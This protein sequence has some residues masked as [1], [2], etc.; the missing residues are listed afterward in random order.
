MI[1]YY[2]ILNKLSGTR[3]MIEFVG[4]SHLSGGEKKLRT[5][6]KRTC[7]WTSTSCDLPALPTYNIAGVPCLPLSRYLIQP[8][9][10]TCCDL[11]LSRTG[12]ILMRSVHLGSAYFVNP[13]NLIVCFSGRSD[14]GETDAVK[15]TKLENW[16]VS[17]DSI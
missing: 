12:S 17:Y 5:E 9:R 4:G 8:I 16:Y 11:L 10:S 15:T 2:L 3:L 14:S 13:L 1:N 7:A 6:F